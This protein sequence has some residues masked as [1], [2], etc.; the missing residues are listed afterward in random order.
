MND[1]KTLFAVA[2]AYV[3]AGKYAEAA[4]MLADL[5]DR[6]KGGQGRFCRLLALALC[7]EDKGLANVAAKFVIETANEV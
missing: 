7:C 5:S 1:D 3:K 4:I 2:R 6:H